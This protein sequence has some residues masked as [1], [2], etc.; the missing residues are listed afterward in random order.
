MGQAITS[1][2]VVLARTR[3]E[4]DGASVNW[5]L[6]FVPDEESKRRLPQLLRAG[7]TER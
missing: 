6:L 2:Q 4:I 5:T 3:F 1:D 7:E